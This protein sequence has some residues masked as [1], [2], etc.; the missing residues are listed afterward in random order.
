MLCSVARRATHFQ[1]S[2]GAGLGLGLSWLGTCKRIGF[3]LVRSR[4]SVRVVVCGQLPWYNILFLV[5]V[6][7]G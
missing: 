5:C 6:V 4:A 7:P 3:A 1:V 2:T